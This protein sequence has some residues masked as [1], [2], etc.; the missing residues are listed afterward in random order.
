[1]V[2]ESEQKTHSKR[3]KTVKVL[4]QSIFEVI[5]EDKQIQFNNFN[6]VGAHIE[7]RGDAYMARIAWSP[8]S[9]GLRPS[10][11]VASEYGAHR[12]I[13]TTIISPK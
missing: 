6:N 7:K 10:G 12:Q 4:A 11:F 2:V 13:Q 8:S 9:T 5:F 1:M 3:L